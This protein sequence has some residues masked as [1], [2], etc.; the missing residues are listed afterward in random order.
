MNLLSYG[1]TLE[2]VNGQHKP[3]GILTPGKQLREA[4]KS[5][6]SRITA[7][8]EVNLGVLLWAEGTMCVKNQHK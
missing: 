5:E 3:C 2:N 6:R 8:V 4:T 1:S 7:H